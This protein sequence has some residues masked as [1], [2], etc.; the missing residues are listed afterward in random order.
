MDT[1]IVKA[2][3]E[4]VPVGD[5]EEVEFQGEFFKSLNRNNRSIKKDRAVA[6][7]EDVQTYYKREVEDM[8]LEMKRLVRERNNMLDLSPADKNSLILASDFNAKEFVNKD[9]EIG[10]KLRNLKIKLEVAEAS[11]NNLFGV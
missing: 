10:L 11:Y 6:I 7:T 2:V 8:R 4:E 1:T 5:F 9:I 3:N